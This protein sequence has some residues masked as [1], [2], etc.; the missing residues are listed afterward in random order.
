VRGCISRRLAP[1]ALLLALAGC[2]PG[3]SQVEALP[4]A[5]S[6]QVLLV[7]RIE[8]EPPLDPREQELGAQ[9]ESMRGKAHAVIGSEWVKLDGRSR[10]TYNAGTIVDIGKDFYIGLPRSRELFYSGSIVITYS[11]SRSPTPRWIEL[12]G[13]IRF[14]VD[15]QHRAVYLGTIRYHRDAYNAIRKVELNDFARAE[16]E[17][18]GRFGRQA[19]LG[20]A[21]PRP[22]KPLP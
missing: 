6:D 2:V 1:I 19:P 13:G 15:P 17:Y 22:V 9:A 11:T 18:A 7:G 12:P 10:S 20:R 8:L 14:D 21:V 3:R 16:R 5:G 4:A